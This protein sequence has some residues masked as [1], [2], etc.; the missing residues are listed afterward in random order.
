MSRQHVFA[1]AFATT[2]VA[3]MPIC[4][5]AAAQQTQGHA[6][7]S[8][9]RF[10]PSAARIDPKQSRNTAYT[11]GRLQ[12]YQMSLNKVRNIDRAQIITPPKP[13]SGR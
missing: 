9:F 10:N 4:T 6:K 5:E 8:Q 3:L 11:L 12:G 7:L 2:A 13:A 1:I